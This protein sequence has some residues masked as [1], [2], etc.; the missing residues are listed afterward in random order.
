M[1]LFQNRNGI[2]R[3]EAKS[4]TKIINYFSRL[5]PFL[6]VGPQLASCLALVLLTSLGAVQ[7]SENEARLSLVNID[8]VD[9]TLA[10]DANF[11]PVTV[12][13][14]LDAVQYAAIGDADDG[15]YTDQAPNYD[16]I[17]F[18][19]LRHRTSNAVSNWVF[20]LTEET[21]SSTT[22]T[23]NLEARW[24]SRDRIQI[25]WLDRIA[26][27]DAW[28]I[29]RS[30]N[31]GEFTHL[32]TL[33][34]NTTSFDDSSVSAGNTYI[35]RVR[36]SRG[37]TTGQGAEA[38]AVLATFFQMGTG[39]FDVDSRVIDAD[40]ETTDPQGLHI[41]SVSSESIT[42]QWPVSTL[43]D[44]RVL[45]MRANND[46]VWKRRAVLPIGST[47]YTDQEIDGGNTVHYRIAWRDPSNLHSGPSNVVSASIP[48][49]ALDAPDFDGLQAVGVNEKA[50]PSNLQTSALS[51]ELVRLSWS[52]ADADL[53]P[54]VVERS[55]DGVNFFPIGIAAPPESGNAT[56]SIGD[57]RSFDDRRV[58]PGE[59][60]YYRLSG[61]EMQRQGGLSPVLLVTVPAPGDAPAQP[62]NFS[63]SGVAQQQINLSWQPNPLA[64]H[65]Y[66]LERSPDGSSW[67]HRALIPPDIGHYSDTGAEVNG[68]LHYRLRAANAQGQS[69]SVT[70]T[71]NTL[72]QDPQVQISTREMTYYTRIIVQGTDA[73]DDIVVTQE[74]ED[75]V[76]WNHG[77][78]VGR[79]S[80]P[81]GEI[82]VYGNAGDDRLLI[83]E[84]VQVR[85]Y[86]YGVSGNNTLTSQAPAKARLIS[87][88]AGRDTLQGNGVNTSYWA[89]GVGIDTVL[90]SEA[91]YAADLVQ[92]VDAF[93]QYWRRDPSHQ[94]YA[95][96][97]L[98]NPT[99][100]NKGFYH[101]LASL[102]VHE[103]SGLWGPA[104]PSFLDVNQGFHQNCPET[105]TYAAMTVDWGEQL[106][107]TIIPLGDGSYVKAIYRR[108]F[109][110][111][112]RI[113]GRVNDSP[114]LS[115][116]GSTG[117]LWWLLTEKTREF[118]MRVPSI[119]ENIEASA[120]L[121]YN[122]VDPE[123]LWQIID[124][125]LISGTIV[126]TW[127]RHGLSSLPFRSNLRVADQHLHSILQTY[128]D[129]NGQARIILRNPYGPFWLKSAG[130]PNPWDGLYDLSMA[131]F[132]Q[133]FDFVGIEQLSRGTPP[134]YNQAPEITV[135]MNAGQL[136]AQAH[137]P[138]GQIMRV[139]FFAGLEYLGSSD[140]EGPHIQDLAGL[141]TGSHWLW[142]QA[143]DN[144]GAVSRSAVLIYDPDLAQR[145]V[146]L[147]LSDNQGAAISV[148]VTC[149]DAISDE[150]DDQG[151][152]VFP[153]LSSTTHNW[154]G[155]IQAPEENQ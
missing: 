112:L 145:S 36:P 95:D 51:S 52:L 19:R 126:S 127:P 16:Q 41:A 22:L 37:G 32:V 94:H 57:G 116:R 31:G 146:S 11:G 68:T 47:S 107:E 111:Y 113:D 109:N 85:S 152:A 35:Y 38:A 21:V 4:M 58:H 72:S 6:H 100:P 43:P 93:H 98:N 135:S 33:D 24:Q 103:D 1:K 110:T 69:S 120:N 117:N 148:I 86:V 105:G 71:A 130:E 10:W 56:Q 18:Y 125:H 40:P 74:G 90:A 136:V 44:R 64:T 88:G 27:E 14:S 142:A 76:V 5:R 46:G 3:N 26:D 102:T 28:V 114:S 49:G 139:D 67:Q 97:R 78:E 53:R 104:G 39:Y 83:D 118:G 137:D 55:S 154:F 60:Y 119:L 89:D 147:A 129:I 15:S 141:D 9:V 34:P 63:A 144:Q 17:Y 92:R 155:F 150:A 59:S 151:P 87:I 140:A 13:R 149:N 61:H 54:I 82:F 101:S 81:F 42:L 50:I 128:R 143:W 23:I 30:R 115:M 91:E 108:D 48:Q 153:G 124:Q 123:A 106:E 122:R 99:Y 7:A 80:G 121:D 66:L 131:D 134:V 25:T 96:K 62:A 45:L 8:G 2:F 132:V 133:A 77:T 70:A 29:E 138:D 12:E 73:N 75:I 20:A 84:S 79:R 65:G